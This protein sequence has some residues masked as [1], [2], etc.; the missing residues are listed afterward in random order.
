MSETDTTERR[1]YGCSYGCGNPFDFVITTVQDSTTL[2]LCVPCYVRTA[3]DVVAA[4]TEPN[5]PDVRDR[6][7]DAGMV[8]TVPMTG[9]QVAPR[10]HEAPVDSM[11]PDAIETF[12]SYILDDEV[13]DVL[14]I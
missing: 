14:G 7:A 10:G 13:S 3:M 12:E 1:S 6:I 2:M 5:N 4:I 9:R 8:D 11:D